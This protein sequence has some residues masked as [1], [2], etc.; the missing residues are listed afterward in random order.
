[1]R[2]FVRLGVVLGVAAALAAVSHPT[3]AHAQEENLPYY[4]KDRGTGQPT[5]MFGTFIRKGELLVFPFYE[6]YL[7]NDYEYKPA[8][9][10]TGGI[11][12]D[13]RGEFRAH[14]GL[15]WLGYGFTDWFA[16]EFEAAVIT[17]KLTKAPND[18]TP[19]ALL[20]DVLEESGLG[21]VEG[22]LRF[23]F[24][25]ET[26]S[27]PEFF[28]YFEAVSPAQKEKKLIGTADWEVKPGLG[29]VKGFH[30]GTIKIRA[31]AEYT[32]EDESFDTGEYALEYLKRLSP[33]WRVY[34][35]LEGSQDELSAIT[36][37]QYFFTDRIYFKFNN[38]FGLTSKAT[39]WAPEYGV[40]FS[41]PIAE[42]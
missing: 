15:I 22:Q 11:E 26:E 17:A 36:E 14:E 33:K 6:Y 40:M 27:R 4:L 5:S 30:W 1:M 16:V 39:D 41:F 42:N 8:E 13:F 12:E 23:R 31:A 3:P 25:H 35:G 24:N 21:D 2:L 34:G 28:G 19:D 38:G 18:P 10:V 32:F 29:L 37:V 9:L 20:P 7:D